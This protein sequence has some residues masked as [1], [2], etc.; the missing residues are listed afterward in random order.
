[1]PFHHT[2]VAP[3]QPFASAGAIRADAAWAIT[4]TVGPVFVDGL[5]TRVLTGTYNGVSTPGLYLGGLNWTHP[6]LADLDGDNDLELLVGTEQGRLILYRNWGTAA[7]PDWQF[8]TD[9]F[10]GLT[11]NDWWAYPALVD[12]TEDGAADLFLGRGDGKVAIYY[13]QGTPATPA[14]PAAPDVTLATGVDAAPALEDLNNDGLLDL[15]VG[16]QGGSLY[17]F[18]NSGT[19]TSPVWTQLTDTYGGFTETTRMQPSFV[20]LDNDNDPDLLIGRDGDLVWYRNDGPPSNPSWTRMTAGY[21]G[22]GGSSAVSPALGDWDNDTDLDLVTG[23]HWGNLR[24]FR[25]DGPPSWPEQIISFPFDL[26]GDSAPALADLNNDGTPDLLVGQVQGRVEQFTNTGSSSNPDWRPDGEP[27]SPISG[28]NH[29]H[30]FPTFADIDGDNDQ[31]LFIGVGGW[32]GPGAGGNIYHYRNDGTVITPSW[33]LVVTDFLGIDV[34][35]WST[36]VFVDIDDDND[37]DLFIGDEAG[38]LTFV[39]NTGLPNAPS[40]AAPVT[41]YA[42]LNLGA[43][44]APSFLDADQ[45]GDMD[46]LVGLEHGSL[47]YVRNTGDANSPSWQLVSTSH[48]RIDVGAHATPA[49][50]DLDG[51]GA[52]DLLIGD[53][54]GGLNL[55]LY[56]GPGTPP[57]AGAPYA[58]GDLIE[59]TGTLRLYGQGITATTNVGNIDVHGWLD[60]LMLSDQNGDPLASD[61]TFMSTMMTPSGLPI[62]RSERSTLGLGIP[63]DVTNLQYVGGHMIAGELRITGQLPQD[64]TSGFYRPSLFIDATGVPTG[65]PWL[66]ADVVHHTYAEREALLPPI[67]VGAVAQPRLIWRLLMDDFV[68]GTRGTAAREDEGDFAPSSQIVTQGAP[69]YTPPVDVRTGQPIT[70]RLEPF[71]PRISFTDRR[72]PAPPLIPFDFPGGQLCVSIRAPDGTLRD[73]GCDPFS[74]AFH[75]TKTTRSGLDLNIGTV[76]MDD[77]YSLLAESN[78]F[79]VTF[80]Q[81]GHHVITMTGTISDL[82]GNSYIGGG[83][84]D[85]WMAQPLDIDP[86]VLPG[87]PL[88]VGDAFNPVLQLQP[89]V[90]ADVTLT[91]THYPNSDPTLKE[92]FT[93]SGQA[94]PY[95]YFNLS[96][97]MAQPQTPITFTTPGEYRVDVTAVYTDAGGDLYMGA[98][99]WGSVVMTP[100]GSTDLVA[101]GRRGQDSLLSIPNSDWFLLSALNRPPGS[102][103]HTFNPYFNG[104]IL[105][106]RMSDGAVG[107]DSLLLGAS[108]QDT[109]GAVEGTIR[110]RADRV[111]PGLA[112]PGT[113]DERF[114][115]DEIPLFSST[116]SGQPVQFSLSQIGAN[117]PAD[118]DQIAYSYRSSQRPGVRVREVIAEDGQT[119]GY[120]RLDTLYDDQLSVGILGD[121]PNDFKFQYVGIVFRDMDSGRNEYLGQGSGWI[122]IPD[123]DPTGSRVMPPFAGYGGWPATGGPI[124]TLN[125]EDIDMFILPTGTSPGNVLEIGD[126]FHF[127]GHLMPTLNS[128]VAVTVTS[129]G[130][131]QHMVDGR[132]NHVGY[133]YDPADDFT[134]N[135][136]GIWT[137][138]VQVWHDG[139]IGSGDQVNCDPGDPF[140]P[141]Q[142]C[143]TGDVLGSES[144]RYTFYV[145]PTNTWPLQLNTP[146]SGLLY[147]P[148][149]P[150]L[151]I[152]I[153]GGI[154]AGLT[155]VSVDVTVSMPGYIL[156]HEAATISGTDFQFVFDPAALHNAFPNLDLTG[157]DGPDPGLAD[158]FTIGILLEGQ[159]AGTPVYQATI[160]TLQG[161][162]VFIVESLPGL[163]VKNFLPAVVRGN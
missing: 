50:A 60:L 57:A 153:T 107:G 145:V 159:Q 32:Q 96:S 123:S 33:T 70:Y 69:Y 34:G 30:A 15:V 155:N 122:F 125:G 95:G 111:L 61:N 22:F 77:V 157:R 23:E 64:V 148:S 152:T 41:T 75:R 108:V 19:I 92:T 68:Q 28:P 99:V 162:Q 110:M 94:N 40:W 6:T 86:G 139:Q 119:G 91:I 161:D 80:D 67:T 51:D 7:V 87:T 45:D 106:S 140:N 158:T 62:Q 43:Y 104:D 1:V 112:S 73:L 35:G 2:A 52:L 81:Y 151:P 18:Q 3:R 66:G 115:K 150:V 47:A 54:D 103:S 101:H 24:F 26:A 129:P 118:V 63:F 31:D 16:H 146:S 17:H 76:Q 147:F 113:L 128:R 88:A 11:V 149:G 56:Q 156:Q 46:M 39:E 116:R 4:G 10:A 97:A 82:W 36:P 130:G 25:N 5:W 8:E 42:G 49:T 55:Y 74:Q 105:W 131:G 90:P 133:F 163:G 121:Q 59:I 93:I 48:P 53:G 117:I 120:W 124:L 132:A 114:N 127:A 71:L 83:T 78:R 29:P 109:V 58:P 65:T 154:P 85:L 144:G 12:V 102:V 89:R 21:M 79:R 142:P 14:Y 135:E 44:S 98:M 9:Q 138:D 72:I 37:L 84:Y 143:P 100:E 38:T 160:V 137:V 126:T 141:L 13:N 134:V 20:D 136:E 27:L